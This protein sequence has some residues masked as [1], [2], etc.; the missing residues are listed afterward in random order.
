MTVFYTCALATLVA[1]YIVFRRLARAD[2]HHLR[3]LSP[4]T[5]GLQL[6]V[7]LGLF[8]LPYTFNPPAWPWFWLLA[9]PTSQEQ[10][11]AGLIAIV[12]G[13]MLA[14][15]VM[16][17]FGWRRA[18]GLEVKGLV[19]SGLYRLTRNPQVL[20]GYLMVIGLALQWPSFD[21]LTFI[22]VYGIAVH[23]MILSEEE[24]LLRVFGKE[25]AAYCQKTPRYFL[26]ELRK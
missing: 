9:G 1:A 24:H 16:A 10:Q 15:G 11:I 7:F 12:L 26:F 13:L 4:R 19:R 17:R 5:A 8:A 21:A 14:F 25:Y 23:W 3:R 20:G 6:M 18:L 22:G 2:Y